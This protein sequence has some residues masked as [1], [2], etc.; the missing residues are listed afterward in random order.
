MAKKYDSS[1]IIVKNRKG[2]AVALLNPNQ[3]GRK[4]ATE[5][6]KGIRYTNMALPKVDKDGVVQQLTKGQRAYRAGYLQA[7]QDN[8]NAYNYKND[9]PAYEKHKEKM[10]KF[11]AS[12]KNDGGC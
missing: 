7:R 9:K 1:K 3:R 11:W 12:R 4:Y 5:L 10:R 6:K 2:N 8:A